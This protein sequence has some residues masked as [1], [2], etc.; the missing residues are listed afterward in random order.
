MDKAEPT[1]SP[2]KGHVVTDDD[3]AQFLQWKEQKAK[4]ELQEPASASTEPQS[5]RQRQEEDDD[6][7]TAFVAQLAERDIELGDMDPNC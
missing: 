6:E 3:Y 2:E 1:A 7:I 4:G 5:K